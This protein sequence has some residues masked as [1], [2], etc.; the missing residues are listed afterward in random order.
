MPPL[1]TELRK[2]PFPSQQNIPTQPAQVLM[3]IQPV[4]HLD[5]LQGRVVTDKPPNVAVFGKKMCQDLNRG[6]PA[7]YTNTL[8]IVLAQ[9]PDVSAA[10]YT[11]IFINDLHCLH[12]HIFRSSVK[13]TSTRVLME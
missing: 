8:P 10:T 1:P 4:L 3:K 11:L 5:Q 9:Q 7:Y 6:P 13:C 12:I 2:L